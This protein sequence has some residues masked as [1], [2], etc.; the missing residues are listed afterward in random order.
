MILTLAIQI[1][2]CEDSRPC[3]CVDL[4]HGTLSATPRTVQVHYNDSASGCHQRHLG[5]GPERIER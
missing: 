2:A 4:R 1:S 5:F 3:S